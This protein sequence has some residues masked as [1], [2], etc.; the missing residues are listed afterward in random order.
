MHSL[1]YKTMIGYIRIKKEKVN[2]TKVYIYIKAILYK[3]I[4]G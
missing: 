2:K 4:L 3:H 1:H